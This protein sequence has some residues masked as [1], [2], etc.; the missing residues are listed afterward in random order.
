MT[1]YR[2]LFDLTGKTAVVLG[3]ASGIGKSSAEALAGLGA[4]VVLRR[5]CA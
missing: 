4:R 3:A 1:D 5:S 2:K